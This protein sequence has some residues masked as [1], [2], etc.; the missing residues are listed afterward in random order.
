MQVILVPNQA[1]CDNGFANC[2]IEAKTVLHCL[3]EV[4]V[5]HENG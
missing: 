1:I 2:G 5:D 4:D 3:F